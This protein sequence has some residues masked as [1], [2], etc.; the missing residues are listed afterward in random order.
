MGI[1]TR[2]R[3]MQS[4]SGG[5]ACAAATRGVATAAE[6]ERPPNILFAIA[7]DW[8]WPHASAYGAPAVRTPAFD[9]VAREGCLFTN[10]LAAAPQCSPNR[11]ACLT[12]RPIWQLEEAGTHG[13]IFPNKFRVYPNI[14]EDAGYHVGWTG[15]GWGPGDWARGGWTRNPAGTEY[16]PRGRT[17]PPA[18]GI[19]KVDYAGAFDDFLEARPSGKPFCFWFGA[20]EPHRVYEEGS[21]L[22][23]GK[24]LSD[25]PVP[26]FL[27]DAP[28]VRSDIL[29]YLL[30]VEWFDATLGRIL[31]RLEELGELDNTLVVVTADNG[32]A[33]PHAKANVYEYG[34]HVPLAV[35]WPA[36]VPGARVIDELVSFLDFAPTF[37]EAAGETVP[38]EMAGRSLLPLLTQRGEYTPR[39]H[40]LLGRERHTHAR[41]DNLGYPARAIRTRDHL[42]VRNF[43]PDRWPM[44]DPEGYEDTDASP[45]KSFLIENRET[46]PELFQASFGKRPEEELYDVRRDPACLENLAEKPEHAKTRRHL[47]ERLDALLR[48]QGD[49]RVLGTGDVFESYPRMSKMR[50]ELGGFA[51]QGQYNPKYATG[52]TEN[53]TP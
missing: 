20:H 23:A 4:V 39:D 19:S 16:K 21:G 46:H 9:R 7:D 36:A 53:R 41:Y 37:L 22:R 2:R 15:K 26:P 48:E 38:A 31:A 13:S 33:F 10:A 28:V 8:S 14:L 18:T 47:R 50:P 30:E 49:P 35:R 29:D 40:A 27:P 3:F 42:Y 25:A 17:S 1:I 51:K 43:K 34:A 32:M 12:G 24:A 5:I 52:T 11:A 45:T 44:G 6:T